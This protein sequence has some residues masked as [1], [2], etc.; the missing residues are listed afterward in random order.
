MLVACL[1]WQYWWAHL[2]FILTI[3]TC[4]CYNASKHYDDQF[5]SDRL[6]EMASADPIPRTG[7]ENKRE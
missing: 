5:R 3:C 6:I 4:S 1:W 7:T 2:S